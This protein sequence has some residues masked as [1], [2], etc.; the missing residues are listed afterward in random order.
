MI[1]KSLL[2]FEQ[3]HINVFSYQSQ[4]PIQSKIWV[5]PIGFI[6]IW[7][8]VKYEFEIVYCLSLIHHLSH[9]IYNIYRFNSVW[10]QAS[11]LGS[12]A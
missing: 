11:S 12:S 1:I 5:V 9:F 7:E 4:Y 6:F 3:V 8:I 10:I 2:K